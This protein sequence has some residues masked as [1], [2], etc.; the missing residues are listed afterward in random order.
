DEFAL[1]EATPAE[2]E[3]NEALYPKVGTAATV[4]E[5]NLVPVPIQA[6]QLG[7]GNKGLGLGR[8]NPILGQPFSSALNDSTL[9]PA[10]R[11]AVPTSHATPRM[12]ISKT[13]KIRFLDLEATQITSMNTSTDSYIAELLDSVC[14]KWGL[15]KGNHLLKVT[16]SNTVAPLDRTVEALGDIAELD[17]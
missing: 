2:F 13:L 7:S 15:D 8:V 6:V 9:T 10:D 16:G 12:G 14:K 4:D 17:L 5:S 3:E 1:V 11:P